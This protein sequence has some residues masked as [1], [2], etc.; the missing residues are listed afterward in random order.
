M[1]PVRT[2]D[3]IPFGSSAAKE[4]LIK[5]APDK[6]TV[7]GRN[8]KNEQMGENLGVVG[9]NHGN[10][11]AQ[12]TAPKI[13]SST[14]LLASSQGIQRASYARKDAQIGTKQVQ[15]GIERESIA[16]TGLMSP[17][18]L[19]VPP[20]GLTTNVKS[21]ISNVHTE[22]SKQRPA[23]IKRKPLS[24][25]GI[26]S[27][28]ASGADRQDSNRSK[29]ADAADVVRANKRP[30]GDASNSERLHG[31]DDRPDNNARKI[32]AAQQQQEKTR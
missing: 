2:A 30:H 13:D 28:K 20:S 22:V 18:T 8:Q 23:P 31:S 26:S 24:S 15:R 25:V 5:S 29:R 9:K 1:S 12:S 16:N 7:R 4:I 6:F 10:L 3:F 17:P 14:R 27:L 32:G 11:T 19:K 21:N